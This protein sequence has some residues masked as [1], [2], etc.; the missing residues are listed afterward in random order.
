LLRNP[1]VFGV[2]KG[3]NCPRVTA[4]NIRLQCSIRFKRIVKLCRP[5]FVKHGSF[6]V[7]IQVLGARS[8]NCG[9]NFKA[10]ETKG[11]YSFNVVE[12]AQ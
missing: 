11:I 1:K 3:E 8:S 5:I 6:L 10:Y 4:A 9:E 7:L 12:T 2:S